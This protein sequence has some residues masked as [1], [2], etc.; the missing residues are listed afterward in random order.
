MGTDQYGIN[1]KALEAIGHQIQDIKALGVEIAIVIGG[2]NIFRG[3]NAA[4]RGMDRITGDNMGMLATVMN[5]LAMMD[6]LE[7]MGIF[8]RV[9]SAISIE[10]V[11]ESY[12]ANSTW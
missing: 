12:I 5:S 11:A 8:T 3:L 1:T 2:G 10:A 9:M 6:T 4:E 7:Q